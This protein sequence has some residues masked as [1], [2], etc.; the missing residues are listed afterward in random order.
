[1][2][3]AELLDYDLVEL[4]LRPFS[5]EVVRMYL[6]VRVSRF[7]DASLRNSVALRYFQEDPSEP[8][9]EHALQMLARGNWPESEHHA[10]LLFESTRTVRRIIAL[11]ILLTIKSD[12]FDSY[13]S[14]AMNS[15]DKI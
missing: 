8:V 13:L 11:Q 4:T 12:L 6:L 7:S 10:K 1:L 3:L 15:G 14:L 9:R 5:D 2:L